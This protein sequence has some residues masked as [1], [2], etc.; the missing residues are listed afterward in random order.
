[1]VSEVFAVLQIARPLRGGAGVAGIEGTGRDCPRGFLYC[2][3]A[4]DTV[5]REVLGCEPAS[6]SCSVLA[7]SL[8]PGVCAGTFA[9]GWDGVGGVCVGVAPALS[10]SGTKPL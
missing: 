3:I 1:M 9:K 2:G 4:V 5:S 6:M 8:P 10:P 7:V